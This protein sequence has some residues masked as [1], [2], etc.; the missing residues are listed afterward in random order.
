M[1]S[2]DR[3]AKRLLTFACTCYTKGTKDFDTMSDD[4]FETLV[5]VYSED[6]N[7]IAKPKNVGV[8]QNSIQLVCTR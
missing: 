6:E 2:P 5:D 8:R 1:K 4:E 3:T 7:V